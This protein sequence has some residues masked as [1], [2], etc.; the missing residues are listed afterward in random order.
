[1][2]YFG[3]VSQWFEDK[4]QE[5]ENEEQQLRK[6]QAVVD[7]L[8]NHRKG[9]LHPSFFICLFYQTVSIQETEYSSAVRSLMVKQAD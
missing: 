9:E 3:C 6:L 4:F 1:M 5:M 2:G 8:V 7:S